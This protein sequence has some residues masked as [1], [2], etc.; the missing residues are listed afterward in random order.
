MEVLNSF[1]SNI[2]V[3]QVSRKAQTLQLVISPAHVQLHVN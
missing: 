3:R 2:G 1:R